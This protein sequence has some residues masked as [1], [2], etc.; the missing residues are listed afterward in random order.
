MAASHTPFVLINRTINPLVR[1]LL[2]SPAHGLVSSHLALITVTGR[3]SGRSYTFPVGYHRHGE[4][5][6]IGVD[7]PDRKR[8]WRNLRDEA[9]VELRL[10]GERRSGAAVARGD[11]QTGVTVE[12]R[13]DGPGGG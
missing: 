12:V 2:R 5:V 10:A 4:R 13:L 7:W 3:R 6:T 1:G 9:P 8:W 11:E